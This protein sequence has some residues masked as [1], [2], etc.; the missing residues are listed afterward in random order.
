MR[1]RRCWATSSRRSTARASA[2]AATCTA[3]WTRRRCGRHV[4]A[5]A[6]ACAVRACR[7][8][9]GERQDGG[10]AR[11]GSGTEFPVPCRTPPPFRPAHPA[12]R[13]GRSWTLRCC[14]AT[15][16]NTSRPRWS[17]TAARRGQLRCSLRRRLKCAAS[18]PGRPAPGGCAPARAAAAVY[19]SAEAPAWGGVPVHSRTPTWGARL[20][21]FRCT[22]WAACAPAA[23]PLPGRTAS[24]LCIFGRAGS[25]FPPLTRLQTTGASPDA[26]G[27]A[28]AV[29]ERRAWR[30]CGAR[31]PPPGAALRA[32]LRADSNCTQRV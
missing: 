31:W 21:H 16:R 5:V 8:A 24:P 29:V 11:A 25:P 32:L 2:T 17:P 7:V 22:P 18:S 4:F 28:G 3:C 20:S 26:W 27:L 10:R 1:H 12:P 13:S 15:T 19:L 9:E 23:F 14:A 6:C 30:I